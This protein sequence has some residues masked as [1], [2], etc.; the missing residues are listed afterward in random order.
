MPHWAVRPGA[1]KS[2]APP[3]QISS[4]HYSSFSPAWS[5]L[6][7]LLAADATVTSHTCNASATPPRPATSTLPALGRSRWPGLQHF[8]AFTLQSTRLFETCEDPATP[9]LKLFKGFP[10]QSKDPALICH[11]LRG[12]Q[13]PLSHFPFQCFPL[14]SPGHMAPISFSFPPQDCC[15]PPASL[16]PQLSPS[17][18]PLCPFAHSLPQSTDCCPWSP[19]L[20]GSL[21]SLV[22]LIWNISSERA[23][24]TWASGPAPGAWPREG[25]QCS[26]SLYHMNTPVL[27]LML[28]IPPWTAPALREG[29]S[30]PMGMTTASQQAVTSRT[31]A[32]NKMLGC[33]WWHS[34]DLNPDQSNLWICRDG[35]S[36]G[37]PLQYSYLEN[38]MDGGAW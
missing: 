34:W 22:P 35:E 2:R 28:H 6:V 31:Q 18:T 4:Q 3:S 9:L 20:V 21:A 16:L 26:V 13:D 14:P 11:P 33:S 30:N 15:S 23:S 1:A 10:L 8:L 19:G 27:G 32:E 24:R 25:T 17:H 12:P 5:S 37:T 36:N 38:P 29:A 7:F